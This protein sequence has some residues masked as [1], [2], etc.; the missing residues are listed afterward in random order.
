MKTLLSIFFAAV[1]LSAC[2]SKSDTNET[3][4]PPTG[5]NSTSAAPLINPPHGQP[6]HDCA[7][8]DGAPLPQK[9]AVQP[10]LQN[11]PP[12]ATQVPTMP[13]V[14]MSKSLKINPAHGQPGHRCDIA[15]GAPLG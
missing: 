3:T 5:I 1:F 9:G 2:G 6:G 14:D 11:N 7:V 4:T 15:V 12:A 13:T 10:Q 8:P